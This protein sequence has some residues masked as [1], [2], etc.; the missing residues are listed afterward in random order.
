M[1]EQVKVNITQISNRI[2]DDNEVSDRV[3]A[4]WGV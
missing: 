4:V 2:I 1:I 3:K